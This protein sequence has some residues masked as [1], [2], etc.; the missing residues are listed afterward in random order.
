[1]TRIYEADVS[2]IGSVHDRAC[3]LYQQI[4]GKF[5]LQEI[6]ERLSMSHA[7]TVYGKEHVD[8]HHKCDFYKVKFLKTKDPY[9]NKMLAYPNGLPGY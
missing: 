2:P 5:K 3:E 1:M 9:T 7:Q 4:I 8:E 6:A